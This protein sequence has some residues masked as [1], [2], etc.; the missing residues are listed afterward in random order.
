MSETL[1]ARLTR[2]KKKREPGEK[3]TRE[4]R[5]CRGSVVKYKYFYFDER[6]SRRNA[7]RE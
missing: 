4:N 3:S 2:R 6:N 7:A 5:S 1:R